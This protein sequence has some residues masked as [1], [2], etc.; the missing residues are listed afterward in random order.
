MMMPTDPPPTVPKD[1]MALKLCKKEDAILEP[2]FP[3]IDNWLPY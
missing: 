1:E 2:T 3:M